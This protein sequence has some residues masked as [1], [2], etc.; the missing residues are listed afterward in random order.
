L[1]AVDCDLVEEFT[2]LLDPENSPPA[3]ESD[4]GG[5]S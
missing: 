2:I 3:A 4:N 1:D 5:S